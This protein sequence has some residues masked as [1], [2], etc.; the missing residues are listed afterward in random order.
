MGDVLTSAVLD[1]G[2]GRSMIDVATCQALGLKW[3]K[4][5]EAEFG[6][7]SVP[8][9]DYVPYYGMTAP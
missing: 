3:R 6:T 7:Y 2:G 8:G 9:H 4:A 1:T 5:K